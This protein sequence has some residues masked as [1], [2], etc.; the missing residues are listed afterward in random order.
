M[1]PAAST[2]V[3]TQ[4]GHLAMSNESMLVSGEVRNSGIATGVRG[5][6]ELETKAKVVHLSQPSTET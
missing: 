6:F 3:A 2:H 4:Q 5:A 1:T